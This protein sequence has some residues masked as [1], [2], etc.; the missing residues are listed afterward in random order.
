MKIVVITNDILKE[1]LL[2]Q[3]FDEKA[4][5]EWM[6]DI[7]AFTGN[8]NVFI[9]LLFDTDRNKR[10]GILKNL[11]A[12]LIIVN[13]VIETTENL[14]KKFIRIN[15]WPT[16]LKRSV[17]E[18]SCNDE[19]VKSKAEEVLNYFN[20]KIEWV[21][22]T[23][24]FITA[25]V[26]CSIINEAY[27]SLEDE[28]SS[29]E[30]IDTAMKLGTNYPYGPFEWSRLIGIKN[31]YALLNCLSKKNKRYQPSDLLKKEATL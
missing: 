8:T 11:N 19:S 4:D 29:R 7:N 21:P 1:E 14:T 10:I 23:P 25:R 22:G 31:I 13:D 5:I 9:D 17:T 6:S 12:E 2:Q 24:G 28:V 30:E 18:A 20:K 16:F 27:F 15:G 26:I 3:G